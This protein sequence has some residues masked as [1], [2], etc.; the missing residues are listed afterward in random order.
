[1]SIFEP[2]NLTGWG[3]EGVNTS[4]RETHLYMYI[5]E[6]LSN[7][8]SSDECLSHRQGSDTELF[9]AFSKQSQICSGH[10]RL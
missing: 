9:S 10:M 3:S 4:E 6:H 2:E 8:S 1:M 7:A 5:Y